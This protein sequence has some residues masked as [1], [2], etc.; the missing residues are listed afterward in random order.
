MGATR[1][2]KDHNNGINR[3]CDLQVLVKKCFWFLNTNLA[4]DT[5]L[6]RCLDRYGEVSKLNGGE[7]LRLGTYR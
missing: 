4:L 7:M 3:G 5:A 2:R 6:E 1:N